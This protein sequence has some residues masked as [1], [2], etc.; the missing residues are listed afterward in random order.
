MENPLTP[1][2]KKRLQID[3]PGERVHSYLITKIIKKVV[4]WRRATLLGEAA[5]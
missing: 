4:E 1:E 2:E 5:C 3:T